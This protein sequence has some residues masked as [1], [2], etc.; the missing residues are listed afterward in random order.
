MASINKDLLPVKAMYFVYIG[1]LVSL[2]PTLPVYLSHLGLSITQIGLIR[3]AEPL[4]DFIVSPIWGYLA[5]TYS[6]HKALMMANVLGVGGF[7][8]GTLFVPGAVDPDILPPATN[9]SEDTLVTDSVGPFKA[10][11]TF[12]FLACL[13]LIGLGQCCNAAVVPLQDANAMQLI[14]GN[15]KQSYGRQRLWGSIGGLLFA[16][17]TGLLLDLYSKNV[18]FLHEFLP[19]FVIFTILILLTLWPASKTPFAHHTP[20][21]TFFRSAGGVLKKPRI[22]MFLLVMCTFGFS[23]GQDSFK[24][25]F[26]NELSSPHLTRALCPAF[27]CIGEVFFMWNSKKIIQKL[28]H[29]GIF[30]VVL[31]AWATRFIVYSILINPWLILPVELLHG[32]CFGLLWPNVTAFCNDVA[33]PGMAATLQAIAFALYAGLSEAIGTMAG[34]VFYDN[35]GARNLFRCMAGINIAMLIVYLLFNRLYGSRE[36]ASNEYID[37]SEVAAKKVNIQQE[38]EAKR[39]SQITP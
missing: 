22:F 11:T 8:L 17:T 20:N 9:S 4:L 37:D 12:T 7:F 24:Y 36:E 6:L 16:V 32:I 27:N 1:A 21:A 28:G 26:L 14:K 34:G 3:G 35:Y 18:I 29:E 39:G 38:M 23:Y 15:P 13:I 2:F 10:N 30:Y 31:C 5:D 19:A 33:P 25:L